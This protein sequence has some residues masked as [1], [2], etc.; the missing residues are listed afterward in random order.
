M[1]HGQVVLEGTPREVFPQV[2]VLRS[3]GLDVPPMTELA[4]RLRQSGVDVPADILTTQEMVSAL[5][6]LKSKTVTYIYDQGTP[7]ESTALSHVNLTIQKGRICRHYRAYRIGQIDIDSAFERLDSP[8][9][10]AR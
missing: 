2:E 4:Y 6:R 5:C 8:H 1:D 7:S 10:P 3:Y 9:R